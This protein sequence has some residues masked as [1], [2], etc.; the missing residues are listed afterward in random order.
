MT[1]TAVAIDHRGTA[2]AEL[3]QAS[4]R[5]VRMPLNQARTFSFTVRRDNPLMSSLR[6]CDLTL[7]KVYDN[8]PGRPTLRFV[9]PII[10]YQKQSQDGGGTL[11]VNCA[12]VGWLIGKRIIESSK[13]PSG[14]SYPANAA[15]GATM[16]RG[17]MAA[18]IINELNRADQPGLPGSGDT[19]L[20]VGT[21]TP[22]SASGVG[23]WYYA[24]ALQ[25]I[26][27]LSATLDGFD[28]Q[29]LPTEPTADS[30]GLQLGTFNCGPVIGGTRP[31][32]VFEYGDGKLNVASFTETAD[33]AG[34]L[35]RAYNLPAGFPDNATQT[36]LTQSGATSMALR[37]VIYED[38]VQ[39]DFTVA[40]MRSRLLTEHITIRGQPRTVISLQPAR[41]L[42]PGVVPA[43]GSDYVEG[44]VV[45]F[46]AVE[47]GVET[48][49]ALFR[50][51]AVQMNIDEEGNATPMVTLLSTG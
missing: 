38:V 11:A 31:N 9:G 22:S 27:A 39:G 29:I 37:G 46:R 1:W 45:Q 26:S 23:P 4:A 2:L 33:A 28:W 36:V 16:D 47:E 12:D 20:R 24:N 3:Q 51:F 7:L 40:D 25:S 43:Y 44:D 15:A 18:T 42:T 19:G 6:Q 14:V 21:V 10:G 30:I 49:N 8:S 48:V 34:L 35:N 13:T 50:I 17:T 32:S 5:Q 41:D